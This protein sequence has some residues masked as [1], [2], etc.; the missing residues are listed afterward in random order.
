MRKASGLVAGGLAALGAALLFRRRRPPLLADPAEELQRKLRE[1]E[2]RERASDS[3]HT[4][5][6]PTLPEPARSERSEPA[7]PGSGPPLRESYGDGSP[8][9][10][11]D[12]YRREVHT[13]AR[14]AV[15]EMKGSSPDS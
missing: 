9:R 8:P 1:A 11:L 5:A 10:D 7:P 3:P 6:G 4:P 13:R 14:E 2:G 15:D 12:A